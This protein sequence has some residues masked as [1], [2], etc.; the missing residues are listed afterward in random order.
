M[1]CLALVSILT[2]A[3]PG[4][5]GSVEVLV[6]G[7]IDAEVAYPVRIPCTHTI[8]S[9]NSNVMVEWF[10][11]NKH[12]ERQRIAYKDEASS[13]MDPGTPYTGRVTVDSDY[14][15]VISRVEVMDE[16]PFL[17]QVIAGA[18]GSQE[19]K[20]ELKVYDAPERPEVESNPAT[21]SVNEQHPSEIGVCTSQNG[22][23]APTI[24][25]YKDGI[26]LQTVT[27]HNEDMYMIPR[28]VKEASGL[29]TV[30]NRLYLKL[31]KADKDSKYHCRILYQ[32]MDNRKHTLDSEPFRVT[33]HYYT[34][35]VTFNFTS[36]PTIREGDNVTLSCFADGFPQPEY[37]FYRMM[38]DEEVE[39][40]NGKHGVLT[41][42][43][44]TKAQSG[45]YVCEAL[46][47]DAPGDVELKKELSITV[48]Y[49]ERPVLSEKGPVFLNLGD[50]YKISCSAQGSVTPKVIWK[51]G[52]EMLSDSGSLSLEGV[53]Y[54]STGTYVCEARAPSIRGLKR[55]QSVEV[56]VQGIPVLQSSPEEVTVKHKGEKVTL[57]CTAFGYPKPTVTWNVPKQPVLTHSENALV[58]Q[59]SFPVNNKMI[60]DG[61]AC[62]ATN[63]YGSTQRRFHLAIVKPTTAPPQTSGEGRESQG[64]GGG[65][66]IAVV[67]CILLL[68]LV[69]AILYCLHRKGKLTCGK[70][71][72]KDSVKLGSEDQCLREKMGN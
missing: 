21:L 35:H 38:N 29:F 13:V 41:L 17:C 10:I 24:Q 59:V 9:A 58:S 30:T 19:G 33:L 43:N 66:I 2:I 4:T 5:L 42:P 28:I 12:G 49:I 72:E 23:P 26:L 27:T 39:L 45:T 50:N 37:A 60:Q 16:R 70:S 22:Y 51:K 36:D 46:D 7:H 47:F 67:V 48:N 52:K 61:V 57:T 6:P 63:K 20:T 56:Y 64:G 40:E 68:L 65:A 8:T 25:W 11:M 71:Q 44:V 54:Q 55:A 3:F 32:M 53:S 14:S 18:T 62:N 34:E 1:N 15:L 69:V 31:S